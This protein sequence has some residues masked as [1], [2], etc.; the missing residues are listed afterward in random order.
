M[1]DACILYCRNLIT[2]AEVITV[3]CLHIG[4]LFNKSCAEIAGVCSYLVRTF[5]E[6]HHKDALIGTGRSLLFVQTWAD[7]ETL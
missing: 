4:S 3:M 5:Q 2:V 6:R 1:N 7:S